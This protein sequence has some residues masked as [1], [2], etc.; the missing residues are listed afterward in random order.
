[1][2]AYI[3]RLTLALLNE[4]LAEWFGVSAVICYSLST[5]VISEPSGNWKITALFTIV[6]FAIPVLLGT[7]TRNLNIFSDVSAILKVTL[8]EM[9]QPSTFFY[10]LVILLKDMTIEDKL[11]E[12]LI[13]TTQEEIYEIKDYAQ[14]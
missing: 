12:W 5:L 6:C 9:A 2:T 7:L 4:D 14:S 13:C 8:E 3:D 1:M 11:S 10:G